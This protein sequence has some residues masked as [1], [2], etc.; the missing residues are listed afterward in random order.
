MGKK[1]IILISAIIFGLAFIFF[2]FLYE[3]KSKIKD[4]CYLS[5]GISILHNDGYA[6]VVFNEKKYH[7]NSVHSISCFGWYLYRK[8]ITGK[9]RII[10]LEINTD[11][12]DA[13][14]RIAFNEIPFSK[15]FTDALI[16][17]YLDG[18]VANIFYPVDFTNGR[19]GIYGIFED[20]VHYFFI[21][22]A[23]FDFRSLSYDKLTFSPNWN[24]LPATKNRQGLFFIILPDTFGEYNGAYAYL[25]ESGIVKYRSITSE[26]INIQS[27]IFQ[28]VLSNATELSQYQDIRNVSIDAG[29][30]TYALF[31]I[32]ANQPECVRYLLKEE[33]HIFMCMEASIKSFEIAPIPEGDVPLTIGILESSGVFSEH[34]II[35]P[36]K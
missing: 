15:L 28:D 35:F 20:T 34:P 32:R 21:D 36:D 8:E 19:Y 1:Y 3:E 5:N 23:G 10:D 22:S 6:E 26:D 4:F 14:I 17:E 16:Q 18:H 31:F 25:D 11:I 27:P 33:E 2:N 13:N 24:H 12:S 29:L 7:Y 9:E 30:P